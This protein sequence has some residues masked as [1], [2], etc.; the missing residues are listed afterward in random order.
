MVS[1][2]DG[3]LEWFE[4]WF[5]TVLKHDMEAEGSF[6]NSLGLSL[7]DTMYTCVYEE[8]ELENEYF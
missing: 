1:G 5:T 8:C 2:L 6:G 3:Y 7:K 4:A